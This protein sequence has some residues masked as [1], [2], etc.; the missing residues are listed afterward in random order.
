MKKMKKLLA[1]IIVAGNCF[2]KNTTI[3]T[4]VLNVE[5]ML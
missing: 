2:I 5:K 3:I 1:V 4:G